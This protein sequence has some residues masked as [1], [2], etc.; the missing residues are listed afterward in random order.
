M[1]LH[2]PAVVG[3]LPGSAQCLCVRVPGCRPRGPRLLSQQ[4]LPGWKLCELIIEDCRPTEQRVTRWWQQ[5]M[6]AAAAAQPGEGPGLQQSQ[7]PAA[8]GQLYE[9]TI[10]LLT[11][12]THQI[13]AQMAAI[14]APLL[15]DSMY[16]PIAGLVVGADGVV[17]DSDLAAVASS[18]QVQG[19]LG[20]H[21]WSL[22][23]EK[24]SYE[25]PAPWDP[26]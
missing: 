3:C 6:A 4:A 21:A 25:A 19:P 15:G 13:R 26:V 22:V 11:G 2:A 12:R 1:P 10:L 23:W 20:L 14:G 18:G 24:G 7:V 16:A 9:C 17:G 5:S 8:G